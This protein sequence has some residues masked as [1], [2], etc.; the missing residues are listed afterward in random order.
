MKLLSRLGKPLYD[1]V[2]ALSWRDSR[3]LGLP[4][5][6]H[7]ADR[8]P[9]MLGTVCLTRA[10]IQFSK[11]NKA[12][13]SKLLSRLDKTLYDAVV[14]LSRRDSKPC[15][16]IV[17]GRVTLYFQAVCPNCGRPC[18]LRPL[19]LTFFDHLEMIWEMFLDVFF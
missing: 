15:A 10:L 12:W 17:A 11:L 8:V 14:A 16:L 1:A 9:H 7:V 4:C 2:V 18:V 6:L 3:G 5:A 13:R 19:S